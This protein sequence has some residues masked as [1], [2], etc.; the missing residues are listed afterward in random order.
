MDRGMTAGTALLETAPVQPR[1]ERWLLLF[2]LGCFTAQILVALSVW[3][4][5][6]TALRA[7][8][9]LG[10]L[11]LLVLVHGK[12]QRHLAKPWAL[13]VLLVTWL[14]LLN[15]TN[16][17]ALA[18]VAQAVL[19][20]A[21]IAPLFWSTRLS[22]TTKQL[23]TVVTL[24]WA[25]H[26]VSAGL[27]ILQFYWPETFAFRP[28]DQ[29]THFSSDY[30]ES[31]TIERPDGV[32]VLRPMGLTDLPGGACISALY[33]VVIGCYFLLVLR[34]RWMLIGVI[35]SIVG[36]GYTLL[37][38]EVR[39]VQ[40][41]TLASVLLMLGLL[42]A[43]R[44]VDLAR[45]LALLA[46]ASVVA[47]V[48][49]ATHYAG[50]SVAARMATLTEEDPRELYYQH[51]GFFLEQTVEETL[52]SHPIRRGAR[53]VGNDEPVLR[54]RV[55]RA[56]LPCRGPMDGLGT[57]RRS[58]P[59][60]GIR[61]LPDRSAARRTQTAAAVTGPGARPSGGL[62]DAK[63]C[64]RGDDA[65]IPRSSIA[66]WGW[67]SGSSTD[68]P[69]PLPGLRG[70]SNAVRLVVIAPRLVHAGGMDRP[71]LELVARALDRGYQVTAVS[72]DVDPVLERAGAFEFWRV[73]RPLSSVLLG[74]IFLERMGRKARQRYPSASFIANGGNFP[75]CGP[76]LGALRPR[77]RKR[78]RLR[79]TCFPGPTPRRGGGATSDGR[80]APFGPLRLV[81]ADSRRCAADVIEALRAPRGPGSRGLLRCRPSPLRKGG[82]PTSDGATRW[83]LASR[84]GSSDA[85]SSADSEIAG[86]AWRHCSK[87]GHYFNMTARWPVKLLVA[88]A[89]SA[90]RR[91][92]A[93]S[94]TAPDSEP[95]YNSWASEATSPVSSK[96]SD[97][98]VAP[99][100]YEPYGLGV[101]EAFCA[102]HS[103][104]CHRVGWHRRALPSGAPS[105]S[106][107]RCRRSAGAGK[108]PS[109]VARRARVL[110][111]SRVSLRTRAAPPELEGHGRRDALADDGPGVAS[112][113]R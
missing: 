32:S 24:W 16:G 95:R 3:T 58:C 27:G 52:P 29:L 26:A 71:N 102:R 41:V 10:S 82:N 11:A 61:D 30:V 21:I 90:A 63:R 74:E 96:I 9:F 73:P 7:A 33:V 23:A 75:G 100:H 55:R 93:T 56:A 42:A 83:S 66:S 50:P 34:R 15:P 109:R 48:V 113:A 35:G 72:H 4:S 37:L 107:C 78:S 18:A 25:Y 2:I 79:R 97:C 89:G 76:E 44:R 60:T 54:R 43:R 57:R 103:G 36:A 99:T 81:V 108:L 59:G 101:Q 86:R 39:S 8:P 68:S 80:G 46:G 70:A 104:D 88:G 38:C 51:R 28:S 22:L 13:A 106:P 110:S 77:R 84:R 47:A 49:W 53:T 67:S 98:V 19:T 1:P 87:P 105:A 85:C 91:V 111:G 40:I 14:F 69:G 94:R 64:D 45:R 17:G 31:L 5:G 92:R 20:T 62:C 12:P 112:V 6:R 65:S